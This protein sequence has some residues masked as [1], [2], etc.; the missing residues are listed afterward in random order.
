MGYWKEDM[1]YGFGKYN[2]ER[3]DVL[4]YGIFDFLY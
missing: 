3:M 4:F 1:Q 2:N